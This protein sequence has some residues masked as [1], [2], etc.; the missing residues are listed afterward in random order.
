MK[1]HV[2][3]LTLCTIVFSA[4][5]NK[6][7]LSQDV[8]EAVAFSV[9][10]AFD[11]SLDATVGVY[12]FSDK[13]LAKQI[14]ASV[15]R[16][17]HRQTFARQQKNMKKRVYD[18]DPIRDVIG[19][20][21]LFLYK[22]PLWPRQARFFE[23]KNLVGIDVAANFA[24]QS[25]R[26][27]GGTKDISHLLFQECPIR[28]KDILL[29][30]KLI[31]QGVASVTTDKYK[32]LE[33]LKD[34]TLAFDASVEQQELVL[35]YVR[36][37]LKGDVALG[38]R[39]PFVR[40]KQKIEL[41]SCLSPSTNEELQSQNTD[42]FTLYPNGLI[43]FFKDILTKKNISFNESDVE[44]GL[45]D[46]E[47]FLNYEISSRHCERC[48]IGLHVLLP[49]SH[50]R[51]ICK[52][53]DPE[54]GNGGFTELAAFGSFL[55]DRSRWWNPHMFAQC[56]V[57]FP[58]RP[59]R[60]VPRCV[61]S[62]DIEDPEAA[63]IKFGEDFMIYGNGVKYDESMPP[64]AELDTT[65]RRFADQG[66]KTKI[67]RGGSILLRVGNMVERLFFEK[68]FFDLFYDLYAKW[69][70]Y[71]GFRKPEDAYKPSLLTKNTF[72][73]YHRLAGNFS[74]QVDNDWRLHLGGFYTFAGRNT[75]RLYEINAAASY[76]F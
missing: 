36:N 21:V 17:V 60:R 42:F 51:D 29:A 12:G 58:S 62:T 61:K 19:R 1:K 32:F 41:T 56:T 71:T 7:I 18:K 50:K 48:M 74:L 8:S 22:V 23:K 76:Q 73:I 63:T 26:S 35:N 20:P 49:T 11:E 47:L 33:I 25:Y 67:Y 28:I 5:A 31:D 4:D 9:R 14:R 15:D 40:K 43:D 16:E 46:M 59:C 37:F 53:W 65:V 24:T 13:K 52:L 6:R 66:R 69:K 68:V 72:E 34:Q 57:A 27:S 44:V 30:S 38:I 2:A 39:L 64:F 75:L 55:L 54:L 10:R 70:D 45:G 3:I